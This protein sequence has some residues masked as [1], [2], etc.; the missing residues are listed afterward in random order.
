MKAVLR[1]AY[2]NSMARGA[3]SQATGGTI[4]TNGSYTIHTFTTSG[5]FT[6][7]SSALAC[8]ILVVAGGCGGIVGPCGC[9]FC[10]RGG[11]GGSYNAGTTQSAAATNTGMGY[12][13]ILK[14]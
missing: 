13:T 1:A 14:N 2:A 6:V 4:T 11:G 5:T 3:V 10:Y 9:G 8:D 7:L 12:V